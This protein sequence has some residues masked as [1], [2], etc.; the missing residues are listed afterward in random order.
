[1]INR[2]II[3]LIKFLGPSL[4]LIAGGLFSWSIQN[5]IQKLD[6]LNNILR[7]TRIEKYNE[8]LK[9]I[10]LIYSNSET[11]QDEAIKLLTS[12]EYRKASF[13]LNFWGSDNVIQSFNLLMQF[14]Y[15]EDKSDIDE[16]NKKL[17]FL[18]G[19]FL[20]EIRKDFGNNKTELNAYDM[21]KSM[22]TDIDE[23]QY[24]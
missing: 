3:H 19:N 4:L 5:K 17:L 6:T 15:N 11:S 22:I 1:M 21:L 8:I 12:Y 2:R 23:Y 14:I 20:L 18:F 16:Y 13:E 24:N 7:E 9:P 10:I